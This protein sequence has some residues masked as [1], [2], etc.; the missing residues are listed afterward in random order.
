AADLRFFRHLTNL[1]CLSLHGEASDGAE[2]ASRLSA[3]SAKTSFFMILSL[4]TG[5]GH[6][7]RCARHSARRHSEHLRDGPEHSPRGAILLEHRGKA[8]KRALAANVADDLVEVVRREPGL[9]GRGGHGV[10]LHEMRLA[11]GGDC[12]LDLLGAEADLRGEVLDRRG[13][14]HLAEDGVEDAHR[15]SPSIA[16]LSALHDE[17]GR[18]EPRAERADGI[19]LAGNPRL[20]SPYREH[21]WYGTRRRRRLRDNDGLPLTATRSIV[22]DLNKLLHRHQLSLMVADKSMSPREKLA[23]QQHAREY[24]DE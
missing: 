6:H 11:E 9:L 4:G 22:M 23:Q 19:S 3:A 20:Q 24:S 13:L 2:P 21:R 7:R 5:S 10:A 15:G 17:D 12:L 16:G 18:I 14:R 8:A 1:P